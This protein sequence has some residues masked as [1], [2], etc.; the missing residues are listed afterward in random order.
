MAYQWFFVDKAIDDAKHAV[1][2][3]MSGNYHVK[4]TND[5]GEITSEVT[6]L[7]V[8]NTPRI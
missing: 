3:L 6:R 8:V 1:S 2:T 4:V 5:Y 7:I